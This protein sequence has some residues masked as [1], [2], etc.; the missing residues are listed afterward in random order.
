MSD[1]LPPSILT[2]LVQGPPRW[3]GTGLNEAQENFE[4]ALVV[5]TPALPHL[6]PPGAMR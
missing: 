2:A 4:G 1:P 6:K 3:R 5:P